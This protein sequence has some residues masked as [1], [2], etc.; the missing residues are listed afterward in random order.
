MKIAVGGPPGSGKSTISFLLS[1]WLT[2]P[3]YSLDDYRE[4]S[5]QQ[6]GYSPKTA[7]SILKQKGALALHHYESKFELR[8]LEHILKLNKSFIIDLSGGVLFQHG[9]KNKRRLYVALTK[10]N[11]LLLAS[12]T[13]NGLNNAIN[14]LK[15]RIEKRENGC[16]YVDHWIKFGGIDFLRKIVN[17]TLDIS[18]KNNVIYID[19]ENFEENFLLET[20]QLFFKE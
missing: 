11:L 9:I 2:L 8:A 10:I 15:D 20:L 3:V 1:E 5:Y 17:I 19:T 13:K 16:E 7:E 12:P 6:W 14:I 4:K 18:K